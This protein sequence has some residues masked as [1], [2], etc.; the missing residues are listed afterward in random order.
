[1]LGEWVKKPE[2]DACAIFV[3]G[4][5]S[6]G[7]TCWR[8]G[9]F[10]WPELLSQERIPGLGVYV[11]SYRS[12]AFSG[13]YSLGD[14]VEALHAYL[15]LDDLLRLRNLIFV[16]HSMGGIVVRQMLVTRQAMLIEKG[17]RIGLFLVASPSLGSDYANLVSLLAK[18]LGNTQAQALRFANNNTWLNDLDVNFTNLKESKRLFLDGQEIVE[19]N[20]VILPGFFR[21][22]V[23]P[24]FSGARY[25]RESLKIPKSDHFTIAKPSSPDALQHRLLVQFIRKFLRKEQG[26]EAKPATQEL[27][28]SSVRAKPE[29]SDGEWLADL[30]G[31]DPVKG[32]RAI[33][34]IAADPNK[35]APRLAEIVGRQDFDMQLEHRMPIAFGRLGDA[36]ITP[37][38]SILSSGEW[39]PMNRA[40]ICC[41]YVTKRA[42]EQIAGLIQDTT[43]TIDIA[44]VAILAL[45]WMGAGIWRSKISNTVLGSDRY[46]FEKLNIYAFR[47][48]SLMLAHSEDQ[49]EIHDVMARIG[50]LLEA[51]VENEKFAAGYDIYREWGSLTRELTPGAEEG[52]LFWLD[53]T[54]PST[55]RLAL[56]ALSGSRNPRLLRR[57]VGALHQSR[58]YRECR[59]ISYYLKAQD[60]KEACA[61]LQSLL[62]GLED[63][64]S[65]VAWEAISC[66]MHRL[67]DSWGQIHQQIQEFGARIRVQALYTSGRRSETAEIAESLLHH[68]DDIVRGSSAIALA[69]A[70]GPK[71]REAV[72]SLLRYASSPIERALLSAAAVRCGLEGGSDGLHLALAEMDRRIYDLEYLWRRELVFCVSRE[73]PDALERGQVWS[74]LFHMDFRQAEAEVN[75]FAPYS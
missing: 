38:V 70:S 41:R 11:F 12:D 51:S 59:E 6:S 54:D 28:K 26:A 20:F 13:D 57:M 10:F 8:A 63:S 24:R 53:A 36:G 75:R 32:R 69:I 45:G 16:C 4:I 74:E 22:Q 50:T 2:G 55:H 39:W 43:S 1:M 71:A 5:L 37:L 58:E 40:A 33:E 27:N 14:A 48:F 56:M 73:G 34:H 3:H 47:A 30:I 7:D 42:S 23:V 25:F 35:W 68:D 44:R 46:G 72:E 9:E 21:N 64:K 62:H 17:I 31:P 19:D 29:R 60:T 18:A 61:A 52:L 15:G 49:Q 67:G 65:W 66:M